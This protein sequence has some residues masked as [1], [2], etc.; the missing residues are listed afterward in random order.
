M[1]TSLGYC[2]QFWLY[3]GKDGGLNEYMDVGH[4]LG[5]AVVAS[6]MQV[7]PKI[8]DWN[9]HVVTNDFFTSTSLLRY[10]KEKEICGTGTVRAD[11]KEDAPSKS[12]VEVDK[13]QSG[14]PYVVVGK[15]SITLVFL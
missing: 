4:G 6:L 5:G 11:R 15:L 2:I 9:Y 14:S 7:L 3:V 13:S 12:N 10:L 1:V 8:A